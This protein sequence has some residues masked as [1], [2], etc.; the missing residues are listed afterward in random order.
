MPSHLQAYHEPWL[1]QL[2]ISDWLGIIKSL[3]NYAYVNT[4]AVLDQFTVWQWRDL[5][6][7]CTA[8]DKL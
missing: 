4:T 3:D 5:H 1:W 2:L 7:H 8:I 6:L